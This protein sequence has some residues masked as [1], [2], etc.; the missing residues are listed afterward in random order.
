MVNLVLADQVVGGFGGDRRQHQLRPAT[1][2]QDPRKI[3]DMEPLHRDG[4]KAVG[5]IIKPAEGRVAEPV[6]RGS[7]GN[8]RFCVIGFDG[9]VDDQDFPAAAGQGAT[10]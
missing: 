7:P 9:I 10:H 3:I 5:G 8:F 2:G 6:V 4:D 1:V